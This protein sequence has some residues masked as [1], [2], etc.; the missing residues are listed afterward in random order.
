[1]R[2]GIIKYAP[3]APIILVQSCLKHSKPTKLNQWANGSYV[4]ILCQSA[5]FGTRIELDLA[6]QF[7]QTTV[8]SVF[9][10][11]DSDSPKSIFKTP[12]VPI[13]PRKERTFWSKP[14]CKSS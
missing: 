13:V 7:S 11:R 4:A 10:T 9:Q 1:M 5:V 14:F 3:Y 8:Q 6:T 12:I 2:R